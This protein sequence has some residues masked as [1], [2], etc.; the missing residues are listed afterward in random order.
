MI[1]YTEKCSDILITATTASFK[2]WWYP[3]VPKKLVTEDYSRCCFKWR[4]LWVVLKRW[5]NRR[6]HCTW[7][8]VHTNEISSGTRWWMYHFQLMP[9][10]D[11]LVSIA[12]SLN[13]SLIVFCIMRELSFTERKTKC[14]LFFSWKRVLAQGIPLLCLAQKGSLTRRWP[15]GV[16]RA[17]VSSPWVCRL[18]CSHSEVLRHWTR[19]SLWYRMNYLATER[20]SKRF[21]LLFIY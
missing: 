8:V 11:A 19:V 18:R 20:C 7:F 9:K 17:G 4:F 21:S 10:R 12:P 6:S 1:P 16:L 15:A 14:G 13:E 2:K 5:H 3:Q